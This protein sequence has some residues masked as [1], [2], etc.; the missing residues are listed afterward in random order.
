M[1]VHVLCAMRLFSPLVT[2]VTHGRLFSHASHLP[3][4]CLR[5]LLSL[6][7]FIGD[8]QL[9]KGCIASSYLKG[10]SKSVTAHLV[11][12]LAIYKITEKDSFC[13][14]DNKR[15]CLLTL[16]SVRLSPLCLVLAG[17]RCS[18]IHL[19]L[20]WRQQLL[21]PNYPRFCHDVATRGG[22][23][24]HLLRPPA[25]LPT[26]SPR[27]A[28]HARLVQREAAGLHR[29]LPFLGLITTAHKPPRVPMR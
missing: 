24:R 26:A 9:L 1:I 8:W 3:F 13:L 14:F 27:P 12:L 20:P 18:L 15:S 21:R 10:G 11:P 16:L 4:F 2:L 17:P 23:R 29:R 28:Y 25:A 6:P 5:L 22:G 19:P 7:S